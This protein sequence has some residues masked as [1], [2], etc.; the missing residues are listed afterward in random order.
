MLDAVALTPLDSRLSMLANGFEPIPLN[1]KRPLIDQWPTRVV[2][3]DAIWAWGT[4]GP[5]TG[6]RTAR[7]PV[8][9]IDIADEDGAAVVESTILRRLD[10]KGVLLVRY[11]AAPKRAIPGRTNTPFSKIIRNVMAPDGTKHKVEVLGD[12]QQVVVD[13]IHPDTCLPYAWLFDQSP[14][15]VARDELPLIDE[16]EALSIVDEC[17]AE[18][19]K[20]GWALTGGTNAQIGDT[21]VISFMPPISERIEKMQYGGEFP[22]NDTLLAY[23][24]EQLRNGV[25]C[26]DVIG[27]C[28]TRAQR[29]YEEIP[30]D[31]QQRPIWDWKKMRLQIEAMVYGYIAK[32]YKD[33]PRIIETL[34]NQL[35]ERWR[36]I[37]QK[38]GDPT[39]RKRRYWGVEDSGPAEPLPEFEAPPMA[40]AQKPEL[41]RDRRHKPANVLV[42]FVPIDAATLPP[43]AMPHLARAAGTSLPASPSPTVTMSGLSSPGGIRTKAARSRQRWWQRSRRPRVSDDPTKPQGADQFEQ[44]VGALCPKGLRQVPSS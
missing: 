10:G 38:G 21:N 7:T 44:E 29:A 26:D 23:S 34:P 28:L 19:V 2:N 1:G 30:G 42:P 25:A 41:K 22:I 27:D 31:P 15:T 24:G 36:E 39:F 40:P 20:L 37:E 12:G 17:V 11:G 13:G 4:M 16:R 5:N 18:L 6:M 35:L 32:N 33:Q 43:R 9:D 3:E 8:F 14:M